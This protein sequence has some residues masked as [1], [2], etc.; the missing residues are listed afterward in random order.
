MKRV[1]TLALAVLMLCTMALTFCSCLDKVECALCEDEKF[2]FLM[3]DYE[4]FGMKTKICS[5]CKKD[6]DELEEE[7]EDLFG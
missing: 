1:L 4:V 5:D 2:E 6:L 3:K 7:M